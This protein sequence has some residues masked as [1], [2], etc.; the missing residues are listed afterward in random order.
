VGAGAGADSAAG[1]LDRPRCQL[2]ERSAKN[3]QK[4]IEQIEKLAMVFSSPSDFVTTC[5]EANLTERVKCSLFSKLNIQL[6]FRGINDGE[7]TFY[8]DQDREIWILAESR[9]QRGYYSLHLCPLDI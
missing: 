2:L 5:W 9:N 6:S 7:L 4:I 8:R 3:P 1:A